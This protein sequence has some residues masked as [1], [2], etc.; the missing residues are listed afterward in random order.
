MSSD[1]DSSP[2]AAEPATGAAARLI[3]DL[4]D[5][6][7]Q[8]WRSGKADL[9][10]FLHEAP[11]E[12]REYLLGELAAIELHYRRDAQGKPVTRSG[13]IEAH[14]E[15]AEPLQEAFAREAGAGYG[16]GHSA[17]SD[18]RLASAGETTG[19]H[20]RCPHC[21][22][23]VE[24]L[25]DNPF[26]E[27]TCVSCGSTFSL[28][29]RSESGE[30]APDL[31]AIGR[32]ELIERLG[33]GGFGSVWKA[34]DTELDRVVALKIPRRGN[35]GAQEVEY[36][37]R[38]A[39][40]AAQL[41]HP[42]IVPVFEIGREEGVV[43]IVS[44]LVQ[45]ETLS[46]WMADRQSNAYEI[47][48]LT[49]MIA[50]GLEHAHA[51]GVIHRDLKP[52]N[53]MIDGNGTPRIMDFGLAKRQTGEITMT[54]DGQ[55]LGTAAYMSPEQ[56]GGQ[57]HWT[58]CRTDI[59]ALG[60]MLFQMATGELPYRGNHQMLLVLKQTE[61]APDLR[62]LNAYIP[63]DFSTIALKCLER[64]P[65]RRYPHARDV[66]EELRRFD[67]G[68]P[69]RARPISSWQRLWRWAKRKPAL[70][71]AA[72]LTL[73][74]AVAGP[75]TAVVIGLQ[76][77][78]IAAQSEEQIETIYEYIERE[79]K[80]TKKIAQLTQR[81]KE[82][83]GLDSGVDEMVSG[84]RHSIVVSVLDRHYAAAASASKSEQ[85]E[86]LERIRIHLGLA[87]LLTEA[88][89][90]DE[91]ATH[92]ESAEELLTELAAAQP[93]A[94]LQRA[95]LAG[96]LEQLADLYREAD[97]LELSEKMARR[98]LELRQEL[99]AQGAEIA[100]L[101]VDILA[102]HHRANIPRPGEGM[103]T[104]KDLKATTKLSQ[105][106]VDEWPLEP[107]SFYEAACHLTLREPVLR[108]DGPAPGGAR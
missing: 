97:R 68:E 77:R 100:G 103:E 79:N 42:Y 67:R 92:L 83:Q 14:P 76:N 66:A 30:E 65:N 32:F 29:E 55:I 70:A 44:E 60:V 64:D 101:P 75:A 87:H 86:P 58:D 99:A 50:D 94:P 4:C 93:G 78:R 39:R 62:K 88:D 21:R 45:G 52:A 90:N 11:Q 3:D 46:S 24:L 35:L 33:M 59:Y 25:A 107:R 95:A 51:Q 106:I 48:R 9:G 12:Y 54:F 17:E 105:Q 56:A 27:V 31:K 1:A 89:R 73:F 49:A 28:V 20:I 7:E 81:I 19:L 47:A 108:D 85:V 102:A 16:A 22:E 84:W 41:R 23:P 13:L 26:E 34:L 37:F 10:E 18:V 98:A 8:Q 71:A 6:F 57:S 91:A 36:F 104:L 61:D 15:L 80:T 38:E 53:V 82:L 5:R 74:V 96:C 40:A 72:M 63:E 2:S 69:I 43:F